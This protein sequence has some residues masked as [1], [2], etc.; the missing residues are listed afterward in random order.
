MKRPRVDIHVI[1]A[2]CAARL[3]RR[4]NKSQKAKL[5]EAIAR[6]NTIL[7]RLTRLLLQGPSKRKRGRPRHPIGRHWRT[8]VMKFAQLVAADQVARRMT[9]PPADGGDG[10]ELAQGLSFEDALDAT[11]A[12][13]AGFETETGDLARIN[14]D[15]DALRNF[16]RVYIYRR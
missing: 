16:C 12:H 1:D 4:L 2:L 11:I 13:L 6:G 14:V 15:R 5:V 9:K 3:G 8:T 10:D 7:P